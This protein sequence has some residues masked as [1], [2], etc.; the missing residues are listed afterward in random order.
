MYALNAKMVGIFQAQNIFTIHYLVG[1]MTF[2]F[3]VEKI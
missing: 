3:F 1:I 2:L